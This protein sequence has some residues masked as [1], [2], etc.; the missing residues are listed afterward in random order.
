MARGQLRNHD[1]GLKSKALVVDGVLVARHLLRESAAGIDL[2]DSLLVGLDAEVKELVVGGGDTGG[3]CGQSAPVVM[4]VA[5]ISGFLKRD[6]F[7]R[8]GVEPGGDTLLLDG[9]EGGIVYQDRVCDACRAE[10][11]LDLIP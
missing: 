8:G 6:V 7:V 1:K 9:V 3:G 11:P 2:V 10:R 4:V 5:G